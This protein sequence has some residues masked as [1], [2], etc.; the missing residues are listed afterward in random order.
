[1][2]KILGLFLIVLLFSCT[3]PYQITETITKDSTGKEIR[4]ITKTYN[5]QIDFTPSASLNV[6]NSPFWF[7]TPFYYPNYYSPRIIV[8][9]KPIQ[10]HPQP[11]A[12]IRKFEP[13]KR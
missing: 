13:R 2:K 10:R 1:M 5:N 12:P 3:T 8:P 7:G 9:I 6:I 11:T 4:V